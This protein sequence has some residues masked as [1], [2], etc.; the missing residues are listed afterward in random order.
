MNKQATKNLSPHVPISTPTKPE[1]ENPTTKENTKT[2]LRK[3]KKYE[4]SEANSDDL[5]SIM[6]ES[7]K[8]IQKLSHSNTI[9]RDSTESKSAEKMKSEMVEVRVVQT[10][11]ACVCGFWHTIT[12]SND[13]TVH[14]FGRNDY[15][16]LGLGHN[17]DVSLPTPIPNLP[18]INLISCGGIF[19][20][21]VD[22][23]GFIWSFGE[24]NYGQLG[25]GNT[26]NFNVPQKYQLVGIFHY[27]KTTTEKYFHAATMKKDNVD[28]V[29]SILLKSH[30]V[31]FTIYL[32]T[33]F[34]LFVDVTKVY[35]LIQKEM[36]FPLD[37]IRRVN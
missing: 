28:W 2:I 6:S 19:T 33:L 7:R 34:I 16:T 37:I 15:G 14:S 23:E 13:G 35:F 21:F 1:T 10:K 27:F 22:H 29:I 4:P 26:T 11:M 24:N 17:N 30:Q 36:Y 3:R 20:V 31:S 8:K 18:K 5:D 9:D 12:L 32:Q 25:T